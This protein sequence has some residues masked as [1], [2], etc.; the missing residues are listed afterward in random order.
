METMGHR[1]FSELTKHFT[2]ERRAY[3]E[4]GKAKIREEVEQ[5]KAK[6]EGRATSLDR[7]GAEGLQRRPATV[8]R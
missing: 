2:P 7:R 8:D 5:E 6:R 1:P 4:A 3:I